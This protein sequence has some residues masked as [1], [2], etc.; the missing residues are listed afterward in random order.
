MRHECAKDAQKRKSVATLRRFATQEKN[1]SGRTRL[2]S[3]EMF[4]LWDFDDDECE[5]GILMKEK[6]DN[7][8]WRG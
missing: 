8:S 6:D 2:V 1:D 3:C 7:K 4:L 5:A